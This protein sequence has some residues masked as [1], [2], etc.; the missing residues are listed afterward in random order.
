MRHLDVHLDDTGGP[1]PLE[2][3]LHLRARQ[4]ELAG[5]LLWVRRS[6]YERWA[7]RASNSCSSQ[8][9]SSGTSVPRW[10]A[11]VSK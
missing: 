1:C 6:M 2:Q 11:V 4:P 3:P 7:M 9:S 8:P 5:D 10:R